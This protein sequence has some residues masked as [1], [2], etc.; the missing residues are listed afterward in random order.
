MFDEVYQC[1]MQCKAFHIM[2]QYNTKQGDL[3]LTD[4]KQVYMMNEEFSIHIHGQLTEDSYL[5]Y[6]LQ[7]SSEFIF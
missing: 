1:T 3:I 4:I 7:T 5:Q 6:V 2:Y